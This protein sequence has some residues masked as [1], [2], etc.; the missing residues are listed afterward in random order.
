ML[1]PSM[2]SYVRRDPSSASRFT[3]P[4]RIILERENKLGASVESGSFLHGSLSWDVNASPQS[5][6]KSCFHRLK[7]RRRNTKNVPWL[8]FIGQKSHIFLR[9]IKE[10]TRSA[11]S[12]SA[13]RPAGCWKHEYSEQQL[14]WLQPSVIKDGGSVLA[15][16]AQAV[17]EVSWNLSSW[18]SQRNNKTWG[19][20]ACYLQYQQV[21]KHF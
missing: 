3:S 19:G 16:H 10:Q 14:R 1:S 15:H 18:T 5:P 11:L 9:S 12:S 13:S 6:V 4:F 7:Y 8:S 20:E 17:V 21:G 2:T